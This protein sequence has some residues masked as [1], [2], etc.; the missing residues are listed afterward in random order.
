MNA[1][2][3]TAFTQSLSQTDTK[4]SA[5]YGKTSPKQ[6]KITSVCEWITFTMDSMI[7]SMDLSSWKMGLGGRSPGGL[8]IETKAQQEL[9]GLSFL[10]ELFE[11]CCNK[12]T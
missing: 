9:N 8:R 5:D 2:R 3:P 1:S 10:L 12:I 6:A 11:L 7:D 4:I